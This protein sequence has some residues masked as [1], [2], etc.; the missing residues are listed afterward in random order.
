VGGYTT[1]AIAA[2]IGVIYGLI[3]ISKEIAVK[4]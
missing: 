3:G 2:I 1:L 4:N